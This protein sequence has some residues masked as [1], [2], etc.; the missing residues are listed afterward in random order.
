MKA[1]MSDKKIPEFTET[2]LW[3]VQS[4]LRERYGQDVEIEIADVEAQT[5]ATA[6]TLD[7]CPA[8]FWSAKG[9]HFVIVK[10]G[11]KRFRPIF[12][13]HPASQVG[14]GTDSYDE[15]GDCVVAVLQVESDHMRKQ[16]I[17]LDSQPAGEP[18]PDDDSSNL[19]PNFWGD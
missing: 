1:I 9:A 12:Y 17:K 8:L 3:V 6:D 11:N 10:I 15:I 18:K 4:T 2:E 13:Y 5:G 19:T 16:K 14:T 7:W